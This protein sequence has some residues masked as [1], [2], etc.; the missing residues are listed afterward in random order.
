L[1]HAA[2]QNGAPLP[3]PLRDKLADATEDVRRILCFS[4]ESVSLDV[5][6]ETD[7]DLV[8]GECIAGDGAQGPADVAQWRILRESILSALESLS[9]RERSV[10]EQRFGLRYGRTRTLAALGLGHR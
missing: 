2:L 8:L 3:P 10:T 9:D 6:V 4:R 1:I 7:G 5:P